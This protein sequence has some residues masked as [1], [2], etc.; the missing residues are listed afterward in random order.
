MA[1][2]SGRKIFAR[3]REIERRRALSSVGVDHRKV[4]LGF[5]RV[6]IDEQV[7]D[8]VEHFRRPRVR[9]I[10]LVDDDNRRKPARESFAQH[11]ARLRQRPFR[12]VD[13]QHDTVHH[14]QRAFHFAAEIGMSR[15]VDDIDQEVVV[16]DGGVLGE[17]RDAALALELVAVH[18]ALGHALVRT[19]RA[20]LMEHRIDERGFAVIDVS[21]NGHVAA[22]RIGNGERSLGDSR[23]TSRRKHLN[24]IPANTPVSSY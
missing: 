23:R 19:K 16:V 4:E 18:G 17:D 2:N 15:R 10:D 3:L 9:A 20:A 5:R 21:D 24:S 8:L 12:R 6:E 1:S 14:R 7:E 13:E 22:V 11:E